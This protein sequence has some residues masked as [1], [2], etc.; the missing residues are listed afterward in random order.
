MLLK[1][2]RSFDTAC[3][4]P[5]QYAPFDTY[6]F[7]NSSSVISL[8]ELD[9]YNARSVSITEPSVVSEST[10]SM[11]FF[12]ASPEYTVLSLMAPKSA[13]AQGDPFPSNIFLSS[14]TWTFCVT[15]AERTKS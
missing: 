3:L 11:V 9:L 13:F 10:T 14:S 6:D 15:T 2:Q 1:I 12:S 4:S 5:N 8:V 7:L